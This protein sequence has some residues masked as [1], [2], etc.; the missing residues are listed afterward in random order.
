MRDCKVY[1]NEV[2]TLSP[3]QKRG[4]AATLLSAGVSKVDQARPSC[5][6]EPGVLAQGGPRLSIPAPM[7]A[8][9]LNLLS[10][11]RHRGQQEQVVLP[12]C[13]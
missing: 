1:R 5:V 13:T 3:N 7:A 12:T 8:A 11:C 6:H 2:G 4:P 9:M 10:D